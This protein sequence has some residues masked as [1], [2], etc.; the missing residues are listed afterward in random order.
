MNN[1]KELE[2]PLIFH[3]D[4]G[5]GIILKDE[6][7]ETVHKIEDYHVQDCC[8]NVVAVFHKDSPL[9]GKEL[10]AIGVEVVKD[11][12]FRIAITNGSDIW[13]YDFIACYNKQNGYYNHQ[14][15]LLFDNEEWVDLTNGTLF[16][17]E[18]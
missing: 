13:E 2:K 16:V 5:K 18:N 15:T 10:T 1:I 9:N 7:G 11:S 4:K 8:E 3:M 17:E 14:L 6:N 12:G